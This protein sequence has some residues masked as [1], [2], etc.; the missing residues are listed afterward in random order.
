MNSETTRTE[1]KVW[2]VSKG[3]I[4]FVEETSFASEHLEKHLERWL[5]QSPDLLGRE[6]LVIGR[7]VSTAC[8]PLDLLAIDALGAVYIIELKRSMLPR[9]AVTQALDYASWLN[10]AS[11]DEILRVAEE[12]LKAPLDETF[13]D[14]FGDQMP[15][16]TPQNHK[17]LV[18]GTGLDAGAERLIGYLSRRHSVQINAVFFKYVKVG[19]KELLVRSVLVPDFDQSSTRR[20]PSSELLENAKRRG[21]E[22]M[23]DLLRTLS[24]ASGAMAEPDEYVWEGRSR[25]FGG[26]FRY[27]RKDLAGKYRM[28]FGVSVT[29]RWGAQ[30]SEVDVWIRP[31]EVGQVTGLPSKRVSGTFAGFRR[32]QSQSRANRWVMR[33]VNER[34]ARKFITVLKNMF[35]AHPGSYKGEN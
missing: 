35:E 2:S 19:G 13:Q 10:S 7:Q 12:Y 17:I 9:E 28:I 30:D 29:N 20:P 25:A 5:E 26:A 27:W 16:I 3:D 33:L 24:S 31:R 6:L 4:K 14:K 32:I 1:I 21:V 23:V 15:D 8:G 18:V 34:E 11:S 22:S